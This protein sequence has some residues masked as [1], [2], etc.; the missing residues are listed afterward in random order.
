MSGLK[1]VVGLG[2]TGLACVRYL[3]KQGFQVAVTDSRMEPPG[4]ESLQ[5]EFPDVKLAL[6]EFSPS[7]ISQAQELIVS[8]GVS[9]KEPVFVNPIKKGI[10][11][12]GDIELFVR[13]AKAPIIAI[14]GSNGKTTVTTLMGLMVQE[15]GFKAEVCGN[16]GTPVLDVLSKPQP[17]FYV[18][19]LSSF[20]LETTYSLTAATA[21]VLNVTPDHM[22]RYRDFEEYMNAKR[23]IYQ[24]CHNPVLNL[25]EPEIWQNL[26]NYP[27]H[28]PTGRRYFTLN[29]PKSQEFGLHHKNGQYYL[30]RGKEVFLPVSELKLK[31]RHHQQNALAC[32]ALGSA[33]NLPM[34][35]MLNVLQHFP[36]LPHRCQWVSNKKGIQWYNDSK[37]TNVGAT[38]AAILTIGIEKKQQNLIL[39]AGG[40]SKKAD[41]SALA[42]PVAEYVSQ[43]ILLGQDAK[44]F[45]DILQGIVPITHV[46]SMQEAVI[47]ASKLAQTNDIVLLSPACA[48]FDMFNNYEHRGQVFVQC[49]EDLME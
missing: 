23:K 10:P 4:L 8:P 39:I 13:A 6:G 31:G 45:A 28:I 29:E 9:L 16:I 26:S 33:V 34:S 3:K 43:V 27:G 11:I 37:G 35:A 38:K 15:A 2:N 42:K 14:T 44:L 17:D 19:E 22:D 25:D 21:V 47:A 7:L 32:L 20:Q 18:I 12:I 24:G 30:A 36:G 46:N 5:K 49:I 48:S 40:L 41:L 1:V